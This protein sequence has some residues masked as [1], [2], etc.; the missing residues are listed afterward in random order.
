MIAEKG[1]MVRTEKHGFFIDIGKNRHEAAAVKICHVKALFFKSVHNPVK[2]LRGCFKA[3]VLRGELHN[4]QHGSGV[5]AQQPVLCYGIVDQGKDDLLQPFGLLLHQIGVILDHQIV[6]NRF[7]VLGGDDAIHFD[8]AGLGLYVSHGLAQPG[9]AG[10]RQGVLLGVGCQNEVIP[11]EFQIFFNIPFIVGI[12]GEKQLPH[13][14]G[15]SRVK[16]V[17][18]EKRSNQRKEQN[19]NQSMIQDEA[20]IPVHG[21]PNPGFL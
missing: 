6:P 5:S 17:P 1:R 8:D 21:I 2:H 9:N 16:Q 18:P 13:A 12:V 10:R 14:G 7:N 19:N 3:L 15:D 4:N 11:A 20:D